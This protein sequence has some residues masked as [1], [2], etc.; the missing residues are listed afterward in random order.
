[1]REILVSHSVPVST[2]PAGVYVHL[3]VLEKVFGGVEHSY[4]V[5]A[6][7]GNQSECTIQTLQD[8]VRLMTV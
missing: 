1:M 5:V 2:V 6:Q 3:L 4:G 7:M 8:M